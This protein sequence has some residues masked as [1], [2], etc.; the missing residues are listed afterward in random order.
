MTVFGRETGR[1]RC[2]SAKP[3]CQR[4]GS[5]DQGAYVISAMPIRSQSA[6]VKELAV[7]QFLIIRG[8]LLALRAHGVEQLIVIHH[9][10]FPCTASTRV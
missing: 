2:W 1:P 4:L 10:F 9:S 6:R 7:D 5:L 3:W 8:G